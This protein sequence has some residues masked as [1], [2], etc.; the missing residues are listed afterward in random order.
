M[1]D[2]TTR[3]SGLAYELVDW[4]AVLTALRA[5]GFSKIDCIRATVEVRQVPL[6]VA[7]RLVH[8]S[9]AWRDIRGRD[10]S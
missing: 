8:E 5:E 6:Q 10:D 4:N 7:K 2:A 9:E 3:A 1:A